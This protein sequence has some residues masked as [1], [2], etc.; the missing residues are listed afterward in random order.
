MKSKQKLRKKIQE[1]RLQGQVGNLGGNCNGFL[2]YLWQM[3]ERQQKNIQEMMML[4]LMM[5]SIEENK[6]EESSSSDDQDLRDLE[7]RIAVERGIMLGRVQTEPSQGSGADMVVSGLINQLV[8][9]DRRIGGYN[10][11]CSAGVGKLKK[12]LKQKK[13][14]NVRN[15]SSGAEAEPS[16]VAGKQKDKAGARIGNLQYMQ[17]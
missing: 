15:A 6:R 14:E 7:G 2:G 13:Y 10:R 17:I 11:Q 12:K 5:R 1:A 9:R 16:K 4:G 3:Q 8:G